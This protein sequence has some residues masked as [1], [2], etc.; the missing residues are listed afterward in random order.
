M[1]DTQPPVILKYLFGVHY[2]DGS[3]FF[4]T[5]W[6]I[7]ETDPTK[8][9]FFDI[10][11]PEVELFQLDG[12]DHRYV[13]DLRDGHFEID[14]VPFFAQVPPEGSELRLIFFRRHRHHFTLGM[15]EIQHE[16]EYHFGWQTTHEGKNYQQTLILI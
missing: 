3:E 2:K 4:Q 6:D 12:E 10:C 7:S 5:P 1:H 15:E 14:G 11:Q 13:V 8:S 9:A 16:I